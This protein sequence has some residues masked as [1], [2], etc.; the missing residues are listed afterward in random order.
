MNKKVLSA[1]LFSALFAGT[2][3]FTSCIDTDE[4]EGIENLRGA[5]AEL[6]RAKVAVEAANAAY[7]QAQAQLV[8][9]KTKT[10]EAMARW[11]EAD[12]ACK[13]AEAEKAAAQTAEEKAKAEK[14][15]LIAKNEMAQEALKHEAEILNLQG[16]LATAQ[17]TYDA[18]IAAIEA[19]KLTLTEDEKTILSDAQSALATAAS[20]VNAAYDE[21]VTAQGTVNTNMT[22][23][24]K[25]TLA[26]LEAELAFEQAKL[27]SAKFAVVKAEEQ[28][29]LAENFDAETWNAQIAELKNQK[30]AL[31]A[32][33][34]S[35]E[36]ELQ[37][38]YVG[39]EYQTAEDAYAL[40]VETLGAN[41]VVKGAVDG[42]KKKYVKGELGAEITSTG[43]ETIGNTEEL[44]LASKLYLAEDSLTKALKGTLED[45]DGNKITAFKLAAYESN[46]IDASLM[47]FIN[48][49]ADLK[50]MVGKN[51]E[52]DP[53]FVYVETPYIE[54]EYLADLEKLADN[55]K[56]EAPAGAL[57]V[58]QDLNKWIAELNKFATDKNGEAWAGIE[59]E[60]LKAA[61][62]ESKEAYVADSTAWDI[63]LK[64]Y[65]GTATAAPTNMAKYIANNGTEKN[66]DVDAAVTAYNAAI[67]AVGTAVTAYNTSI[68]AVKTAT[69]AVYN[70]AKDASVTEQKTKHTNDVYIAGVID[71]LGGNPYAWAASAVT[72]F[73]G[74]DPEKKTV[75]NLELIIDKNC[76]VADAETV[77][78]KLATLSATATLATTDYYQQDRL[79]GV[80]VDTKTYK[81]DGTGAAEAK[82]NGVNDNYEA[83][84]DVAVGKANAAVLADKDETI[85]KAKDVITKAST[86]TLAVMTDKVTKAS[87]A[88]ANLKAAMDNYMFMLAESYGKVLTGKNLTKIGDDEAGKL[89]YVKGGAFDWTTIE[90]DLVIGGGFI[91]TTQVENADKTYAGFEYKTLTASDITAAEQANLVLCDLNENDQVIKLALEAKSKIAF[92]DLAWDPA[93]NEY[94]AIAPTREE[95]EAYVEA[96]HTLS[97][98]GS[99]GGILEAED[100]IAL[101]EGMSTA[102]ELVQPIIDELT[103]QLTAVEAE[104]AANSA[105]VAAY[106]TKY[107]AAE[108]AYEVGED[109]I[110]AAEEARDAVS[111]ENEALVAEFG[112]KVT[113][114]EL[115]INTAQAQLDAM[116]LDGTKP[117]NAEEV[118]AYWKQKVAE[119]E[120]DLSAQQDLV[121]AAEQAIEQFN[122]GTYDEAL[123]YEKAVLAL[124]IATDK[125]ETALEVYNQ[126]LAELKAIIEA[127]A[128]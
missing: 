4:P 127:L 45:E 85:K 15:I 112:E 119:A 109:A 32:S 77:K 63:M 78:T 83:M 115:L 81:L 21:Y 13:E 20:A 103:A 1:I 82:A 97:D 111:A 88:Y 39:D 54:E 92:G 6:I 3:T 23:K 66:A 52:D 12:A 55:E 16:K 18:T 72:E 29:A 99:F 50:A 120:K 121:I 80:G 30:Q 8:L 17:Q 110:E 40:A 59:A 11:K 47:E 5:K 75:A 65:K 14:A 96:G 33:L 94:R 49:S 25:V 41:K 7:V 64:A 89:E 34:D 125:Y 51:K 57:K 124:Q 36:V 62:V 43:K 61:L 58:T 76:A 100:N 114:V 10:E 56:Y 86:G 53:A 79:T 26:Q 105:I 95:A 126:R 117:I 27:N 37:K 90:K 108:A 93:K 113:Y 87:E 48:K 73:N 22:S 38:V 70:A 98:C 28:L 106:Q 74:L 42:D 118:V 128:K 91:A 123:Q 35:A 101:Y 116:Y 107:D 9:A 2:G 84:M 31:Q 67:A 68:D 24:A 19:A 102:G 46:A 60:K 71:W 69:D 104:I 44:T 122:A